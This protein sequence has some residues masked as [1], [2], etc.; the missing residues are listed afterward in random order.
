ML[1]EAI[2]QRRH[3]AL[4]ELRGARIVERRDVVG[5]HSARHER[6][7]VVVRADADDARAVRGGLADQRLAF[8]IER[9]RIVDDDDE[10]LRRLLCAAPRIELELDDLL[11]REPFSVAALDVKLDRRIVF[12]HGGAPLAGAGGDYEVAAQFA[13]YERPA[14]HSGFRS[15]GSSMR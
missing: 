2:G 4:H 12:K 13:R 5:L 1:R 15:W 14:N 3:C 11:R 7:G 9:A 6:R 8:G 10:T